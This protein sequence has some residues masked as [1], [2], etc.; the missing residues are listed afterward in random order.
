[1]VSNGSPRL[2]WSWVVDMCVRRT[3]GY[4]FQQIF[5]KWTFLNFFLKFGEEM[6]KVDMFWTD[7]GP[8]SCYV[9]DHEHPNGQLG[10][11]GALGMPSAKIHGDT[12]RIKLYLGVLNH[13]LLLQWITS[14][15]LWFQLPYGYCLS[16]FHGNT[17]SRLPFLEKTAAKQSKGISTYN[18]QKC[19]WEE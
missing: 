3:I 17:Q 1:M 14:W 15:T 4:V 2:F 18:Q 19:S 8:S 9:F 13:F 16:P 5:D 10:W 11:F 6:E 7:G 12:A